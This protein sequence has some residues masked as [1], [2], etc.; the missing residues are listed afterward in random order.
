MTTAAILAIASCSVG[1]PVAAVNAVPAAFT[2]LFHSTGPA[3]A[4]RRT[5][6]V[7]GAGS[8]LPAC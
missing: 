3:G 2:I 8:E 7:S 4:V 1:W 5:L 6:G